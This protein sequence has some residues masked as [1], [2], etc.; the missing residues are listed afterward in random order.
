[1]ICFFYLFFLQCILCGIIF[2][3]LQC[4]EFLYSYFSISDCMIG[5]IFYFTTG[6]HGIHVIIGCFG[7]MLILCLISFPIHNS[8]NLLK[9]DIDRDIHWRSCSQRI[10]FNP[11]FFIEF[12][13]SILLCSYYWHFVD[14]I[15]LFVF[16]VYF[17]FNVG[18]ILIHF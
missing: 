14:W 11:D 17:I 16:L 8:G 3:I 13:L 5:C 2:I 10:Y 4:K 7:W 18:N 12:G 15:W 6:L 9:L 1:M